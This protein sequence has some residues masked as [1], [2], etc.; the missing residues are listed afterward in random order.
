M[1]YKIIS[2]PKKPIENKLTKQLFS[3]DVSSL[4]AKNFLFES[5]EYIYN[6]IKHQQV[7]ISIDLFFQGVVFL[8]YKLLVLVYLL[9]HML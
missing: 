8:N 7:T 2:F 3:F 6:I 5:Y 9:P 4:G 1:N